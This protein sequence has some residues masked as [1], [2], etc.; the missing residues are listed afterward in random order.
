MLTLEAIFE[1]GEGKKYR[2]Q[3]HNLDTNNSAEEIN[4]F[5]EKLTKLKVVENDGTQLFHKL[6]RAKFVETIETKIFDENE[7]E[8]IAKQEPVWLSPKD[9][10]VSEKDVTIQ[11][12]EDSEEEIM[13]IGLLLPDGFAITRLSDEELRTIFVSNLPDIVSREE[14]SS[15]DE[16]EPL[17]DKENLSN[18]KKISDSDML[19]DEEKQAVANKLEQEK[20]LKKEQKKKI[21]QTKRKLWE[22]FKKHRNK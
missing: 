17:K 5:L 8:I 9:P 4:V 2:W 10:R 3:L 18:E 21:H 11:I 20:N 14:I 12:I 22:R 16:K 6:V 19:L 1:N 15:E 13:Q 7:K